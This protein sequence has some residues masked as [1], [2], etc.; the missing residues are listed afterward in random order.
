[1][2]LHI[3][4]LAPF[5]IA[6]ALLV[7]CQGPP[8][9]QYVIIT[10]TPDGTLIPTN[11]PPVTVIIVTATP[12]SVGATATGEEAVTSATDEVSA[13]E[14]V[15]AEMPTT[16]Y[17]QIQVAEQPFEH[18]RMFWLEPI[19]EI[20]V[21]V[22]NED[23]RRSGVWMNFKDTFKEGDIEFDP[24]IVPP[25]G[26]L[27]P[28]RGFGKLWR[29]NPE[30]REALGWARQT[31]IGHVSN[32]QYQP[33]GEIVNGEYVKGP[34]YHL[35]TSGYNN[36]TYRFNEINGTWQTLQRTES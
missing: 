21:M 4:W 9:T 24:K 14:E 10:S 18:G 16:T 23:D 5:V 32:Y 36:R 2:R 25:E 17:S 15:V 13:T 28:V 12:P 20:W 22:E 26:L 8:P 7:A 30:V 11:T 1:M 35:L 27:Q 3:R 19:N 34:G 29:E 33:G 31:E 6:L